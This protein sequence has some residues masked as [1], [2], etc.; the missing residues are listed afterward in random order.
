MPMNN[1]VHKIS[2]DYHDKVK[3]TQAVLQITAMLDMYQAG[4]LHLDELITQTY[5]LDQINEGYADM[6]AGKNMRGVIVYD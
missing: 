5:T 4:Q 1:S 3:L 6:H 2:V